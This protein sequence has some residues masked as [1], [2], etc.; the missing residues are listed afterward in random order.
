[1]ITS[2]DCIFSLFTFIQDKLLGPKYYGLNEAN[3]VVKYDIAERMHQAEKR[4]AIW[5]EHR[6]A[7][8]IE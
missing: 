2:I 5:D 1:M 4:C 3:K 7:F 6:C 8:H